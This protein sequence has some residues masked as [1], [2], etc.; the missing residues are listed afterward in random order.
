[1]FDCDNENKDINLHK[2]LLTPE[3]ICDVFKKYSVPLEADFISIDVDGIDLWLMKAI[4]NGGYQPRL[5][6]VEY[7]ANF[8]LG[9]SYS[10]KPDIDTYAG[11]M[12]YGASL[13]ALNDVAQ[14]FNYTLIA[15]QIP[16]DL[17]FLRND[18]LDNFQIPAMPLDNLT[19]ISCHVG[20]TRERLKCFVEYPSKTPVTDGIIDKFPHIFRAVD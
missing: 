17:F 9:F 4:L 18:I 14:K 7:N 19:G 3:N 2:E 5:I 1:M 15:V 16:S 8:P 10:C 13:T 6:A 11:D 20:T 12:V